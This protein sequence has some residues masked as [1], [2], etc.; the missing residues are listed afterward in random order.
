M[1]PVAATSCEKELYLVELVLCI[2]IVELNACVVWTVEVESCLEVVGN[3][4]D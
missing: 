3:S 4:E 2:S 1:D